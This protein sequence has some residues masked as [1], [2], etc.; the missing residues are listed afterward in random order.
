MDTPKK[1][2]KRPSGRES[3]EIDRAIADDPDTWSATEE[4]W[5]RMRPAAE[6]DPEVLEAGRTEAPAKSPVK[7]KQR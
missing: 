5:R 3:A 4:E 1:K 2:L 7:A 6:V